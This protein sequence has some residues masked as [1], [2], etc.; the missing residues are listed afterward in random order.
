MRQMKAVILCIGLAATSLTVLGCGSV[1]HPFETVPA[2]GVV[3]YKGQPVAGATVSFIPKEANKPPAQAQ[4]DAQGRFRLWTY[5]PGDGAVIGEYV[6]TILKVKIDESVKADDEGPTIP[7]EYLVPE[8]YIDR[9][10]S[11]LTAT[12]TA[13]GPNKFEFELED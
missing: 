9:T 7:P 8:K 5:E 6:V 11:G 4:T 10:T 3:K 2:S 1:K 12:V 13:A